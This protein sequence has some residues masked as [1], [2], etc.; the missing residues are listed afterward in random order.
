[1]EFFTVFSRIAVYLPVII[2]DL[3]AKSGSHESACA[4]R[5][6]WIDMST[7]E[8]FVQ[9]FAKLFVHY[10]DAL[11]LDAGGEHGT[12]LQRLNQAPVVELDRMISAARL[13]LLEIEN[14]AREQVDAR[15]YYAKPDRADWESHG[16]RGA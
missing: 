8:L 1:M 10:R 4:N 16:A 3:G 15:H 7:E 12:Q 9:Q 6:D 14:N 11:T 13:A 2:L 5:R